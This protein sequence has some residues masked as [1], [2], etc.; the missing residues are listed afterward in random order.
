VI[1]ALRDHAEAVRMKELDRMG[2]RLDERERELL[3]QFSRQLLAKLLH[4]PTV[5]LRG[6]AGTVK[7]QRLADAARS[8][9]ALADEFGVAAV[10]KAATEAGVDAP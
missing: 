10:E 6:S 8:M 5:A 4:E 3:D 2:A 1:R 9:F 7:G